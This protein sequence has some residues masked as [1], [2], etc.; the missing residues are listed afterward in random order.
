MPPV[1]EPSAFEPLVMERRWAPTAGPEDRKTVARVVKRQGSFPHSGLP[2]LSRRV[3][4]GFDR[5]GT[6]RIG[7]MITNLEEYRRLSEAERWAAQETMTAEESI[8]LGEALLTSEIMDFAE[9]PDD[10][11]PVCLA[12]SLGIRARYAEATE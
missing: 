1:C 4:G 9:F 2:R 8:R 11:R 12:V 10:D 5:S 7:P 3:E 6:V